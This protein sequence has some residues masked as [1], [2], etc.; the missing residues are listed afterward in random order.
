MDGK[1]LRVL[2]VEDMEDD[3]ALIERQIVR[4]GYQVELRRVDTAQGFKAALAQAPWDVIIT[5]HNL[6]AFSSTVA[7]AL[8]RE[9]GLDVPVIIVSGSIGEEI[10]VAAMKAGASDYVMKDNLARLLPA[11]ERELRE[12]VVR[13]DHQKA[14]A[15][16][17]HMAFHDHLTGLANRTH[18]EERLAGLLED[19]RRWQSHHAL[20]YLDLDLD[21]D[22]DQFKVVN[23]TC[24]HVAGIKTIAEFVETQAVGEKLTALGP[25]YAQGFG[26]HRPEPFVGVQA[27]ATTLP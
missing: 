16:I 26:I 2:L 17:R 18:F 12:A 5:D 8:M 3:A 4:G 24:G 20:L 11:M 7:L 19:A 10:A 14:K 9:A 25:D 13:R 15:T 21:L 1:T 27:A 6:P 22:L 23:D